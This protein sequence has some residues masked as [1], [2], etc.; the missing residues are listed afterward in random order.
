MDY[1]GLKS[2]DFINMAIWMPQEGNN[3]Q[4]IKL[5]LFFTWNEMP[6]GVKS[7]WSQVAT[8]IEKWKEHRSQGL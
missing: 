1:V 8:F 2:G 6:S 7:F 4:S 3:N 5:S